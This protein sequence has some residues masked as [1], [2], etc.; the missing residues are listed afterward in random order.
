MVNEII[1]YFVKANLAIVL[2]ALLYRLALSKDVMFSMRRIFLIAGIVVAFTFQLLPSPLPPVLVQQ[3]SI[4]ISSHAEQLPAI[5]T[6]NSLE[7]PQ[8]ALICVGCVSLALL[9]RLVCALLTVV[10]MRLRASH[11]EI[12][13]IRVYTLNDDKPAFSLFGWIF[14]PHKDI[15][16]KN[17]LQ[18]ELSHKR[19]AHSIDLLLSELLIVV[20]WMNPAS[21]LLRREIRSNLE[22]IADRCVLS[23]GAD[24][25][26]YQYELLSQF[27]DSKKSIVATYFN[28]SQLKNRI[29]MM[30]REKKSPLAF[31]KYVTLPLLVVALSLTNARARVIVEQPVTI[32]SDDNANIALQSAETSVDTKPLIVVDGEI[33]NIEPSKISPESIES[34][35]VLK[36]DAATK[37]YGDKGNDGVIVVT[38]KKGNE[39]STSEVKVVGASKTKDV[40]VIGVKGDKALVIVDGEVTD[41]KPSE[42]TNKINPEQIAN[43]T[44]LKDEAA[45]KVYGNKGKDGVMLITTKVEG[46]EP[47][48]PEEQDI[49]VVGVTIAEEGTPAASVKINSGGKGPKPLVVVDGVIYDKDLSEIDTESIESITVLKDKSAVDLYGEKAQNGV[50]V[51]TLKK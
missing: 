43:I 29:I 9:I 26:S 40:Q 41:I 8:I 28:H 17:I 13:G 18:H 37:L 12:D 36:G 10:S 4:N 38:L 45:I 32:Q 20:T 6:K 14:I 42:L 39:T 3:L 15:G 30:K 46:A 48:S 35:E 47:N 44:V 21:W 2:L 11:T 5:V 22:Y 34:I 25:K 16:T 27:T 7:A 23:S 1:V 19:G 50:V 24:A 49:K 31:L 33:R 51:I